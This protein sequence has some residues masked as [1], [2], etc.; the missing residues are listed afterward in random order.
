MSR[1]KKPRK[2][3]RPRQIAVNTLQVALWRAAKPARSDRADVLGKLSASVQA[4]CAGVATELDWSIAAGSA[5]VAQA[6]ERQGI[7]RGLGEHLASAEAALQAVYD[8]CR[9]SVMW[10]RPTLTIQEVD[11]LRLLLELHTFQVEQLG[12]AE[13]LAAIDAAQ[14]DTIAQGHTVTLARDLE[15]MAA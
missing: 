6:V 13:F 10:L 5:S 4:L 15:R 12:R 2:A 11:A 14:Q 3:Y 8:R 1:N 9:T 7:V